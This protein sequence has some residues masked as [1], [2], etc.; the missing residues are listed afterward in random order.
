MTALSYLRALDRPALAADVAAAFG[1]ALED[2]YAELVSAEARGFVR[3]V[4]DYRNRGCVCR[5]AA[6]GA[7]HGIGT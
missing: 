3:V 1:I 4:V 7:R 5:W 2:V 6:L